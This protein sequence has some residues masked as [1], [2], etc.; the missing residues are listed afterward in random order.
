MNI[1][2]EDKLF[3]VKCKC[4]IINGKL[5]MGGYMCSSCITA[6]QLEK[7]NR[8]KKETTILKRGKGIRTV[9][10]RIKQTK[11]LEYKTGLNALIATKKRL[12]GEYRDIIVAAKGKFTTEQ[13]KR[14]RELR[15][16]KKKVQLE[17]RELQKKRKLEKEELKKSS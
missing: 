10:N 16:E 12:R 6:M 9:D 7:Y 15:L 17:F 1:S 5:T 13:S 8:E 2:S 4:E 11:R 14:I 3:C